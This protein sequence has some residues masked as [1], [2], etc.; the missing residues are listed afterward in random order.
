MDYN[1][2]ST[3]GWGECSALNERGY[4]DEWAEGAFEAL[5]SGSQLNVADAPMAVAAI[6]MAMIDAELKSRKRSLAQA[7]GTADGDTAAGAVIGLGSVPSML[8]EAEELVEAGFGRIKLKVTPSKLVAPVRSIRAA[9]PD[10]ELHADAN[11]SLGAADRSAVRELEAL[12]VTVLEQPFPIGDTDLAREVTAESNLVVA[13]D[14]S[15]RAPA[16]VAAIAESNLADAV[17]IK[18]GKLGGIGAALDA[19]DQA[20]RNGLQASVGGMLESGLGRHV[21]AALAPLPGFTV[22]GD[23]SPASRWL[24]EDP[25]PDVTMIDGRIL[26]S[27]Q[28]GI[29][30][31]PSLKQLERFTVRTSV[32]AARPLLESL[33]PLPD[34]LDLDRHER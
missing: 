22:T 29:A 18:P 19:L 28:P 12:G 24:S 15:V 2:Q 14:E 26:P 30:G 7:L 21:L 23:V 9:F 25:F 5:Q 32:V 4:T 31:E 6:E 20:Q 16:D 27:N 10:I 34:I 11:G 1:L 13:A 33:P 17:V 3:I 8:A